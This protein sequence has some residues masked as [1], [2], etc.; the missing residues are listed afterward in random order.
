MKRW[1]ENVRGLVQADSEADGGNAER[2]GDNGGDADDEADDGW[3]TLEEAVQGLVGQM[4]RG[5]LPLPYPNDPPPH[6]GLNTAAHDAVRGDLG[7]DSST[8]VELFDALLRADPVVLHR[9]ALTSGVH[10]VY[11]TVA[12][13]ARELAATVPFPHV[14]ESVDTNAG[15]SG[16]RAPKRRKR[17]RKDGQAKQSKGNAKWTPRTIYFKYEVAQYYR[18]MKKLKSQGPGKWWVSVEKAGPP[19]AGASGKRRG[20]GR[21]RDRRHEKICCC[22]SNDATLL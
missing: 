2:G 7:I 5:R 14:E 6:E 8:P 4:E 17:L 15:P 21:G 19:K 16:E 13:R 9:L 10:D 12:M 11:E 3:V 18:R 22:A 20:R 1:L